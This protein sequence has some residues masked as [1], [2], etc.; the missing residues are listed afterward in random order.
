M[1]SLIRVPKSIL[2]DPDYFIRQYSWASQHHLRP[3]FDKY[4]INILIGNIDRMKF[5]VN[6][7]L[8]LNRAEVRSLGHPIDDLLPMFESFGFKSN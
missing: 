6:R 8:E 2:Y 5:G 1:L 3:Q 7:N 4:A